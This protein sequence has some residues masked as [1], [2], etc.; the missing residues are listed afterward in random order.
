LL[1]QTIAQRTSASVIAVPQYGAHFEWMTDSSKST[2]TDAAVTAAP[3]AKPTS[4]V[5]Q[6]GAIAGFPPALQPIVHALLQV[7]EELE[8]HAAS[9]THE[10]LWARPYNV[11]SVG[12]H[13]LHIAGATDRLLTYARGESL[14]AEQLAYVRAEANALAPDISAQEL[15]LRTQ[16]S[17]RKSLERVRAITLDA[18]Y[19]TR[20][21]GKA[22]ME[23]TVA[24]LAFHAAE[25]A[26]RHAGQLVTTVKV[27]AG[28]KDA[29]NRS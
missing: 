1:A 25:H 21:V 18:L 22:R 28:M 20:Y 27:L 16:Q 5:W 26:A 6:R 12:F 2:E 7:S 10:Q 17:L 4:E 13:L 19:E 15:V 14:S 3:A 24:G 8:R 11:A 9:L 29:E 23:S